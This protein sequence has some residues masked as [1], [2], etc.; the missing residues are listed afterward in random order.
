MMMMLILVERDAP[1]QQDV[2]HFPVTIF[3]PGSGVRIENP[4]LRVQRYARQFIEFFFNDKEHS[5]FLSK[6]LEIFLKISSNARV[7]RFLSDGR[8]LRNRFSVRI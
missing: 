1:L 8:I 2:L 4:V 6:P 7:L 3:Y 5:F